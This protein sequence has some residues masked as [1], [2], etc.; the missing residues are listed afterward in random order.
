MIETEN[1]ELT[2]G[3]SLILHSL[4]FKAQAGHVTTII[5]TNGS[6]KTT[7]IKALSGELSY[8]GKI[9]INGEDIARKKPSEMALVRA[10]LQQST[11]VSFP[12]LVREV[13]ALGLSNSLDPDFIKKRLPE[14][15]LEKVD[16]AGYE[17]RFYH[18]LSGGEQ[19]RVQLARVMCQIWE[20]VF[21]GIP[22]WLFLDEPVASLDI[23]HQ[24]AVM[25]IAR[26]F[27]KAGG[28]VIAILHDLN[29]AAH[30]SDKIIVMDHGHIIKE[31][32][33]AAVLTTPMLREIY[34]CKLTV[35]KIPAEGVP[36]VLPQS[37]CL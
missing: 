22:R 3:K 2:L 13:V 25:D 8:S 37:A 36:F 17:G 16:L 4:N 11:D 30:Y 28:G 18:E 20:P 14:M 19:A 15:A 32:S 34:H 23:Y 21:N 9:T 35:G 12:F 10:V 1:L 5:G 31:G 29:L 7:L 33:P 24:L 27:S 6:G 26:N